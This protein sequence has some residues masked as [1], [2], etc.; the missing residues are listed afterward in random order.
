MK[1]F[2][3]FSMAL[4][5]LNVD[6][7]PDTKVY[8]LRVYHCH[9][10]KRDDLIARFQNHTTRIFEKHG[11]TNVAYWLPTS[12]D[13]KNDLIYM[14]SYPSMEA[15]QAAWKAFSADPEWQKVAADSQKDGKIVAA[16]DS[17]FL[18]MEPELTKKLKLKA[19]SPERTFELRSYY[20]LPGRY[21]NIV[22]RFRDHT[23]DIFETHGIENIAYWGTIEKENTQPHLVYI[24]A[25]ESEAAAKTSWDAFRADPVW[26]K[27][28]KAS[29]ED[30]KIVEKV[31]SIMMEPLPFSKLK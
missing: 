23:R 11:M 17:K 24:I 6:A 18:K 1:L 25:H 13:M 5:A 30:G 12:P 21:P 29:E 10:G 27:A 3:L 15:R 28:Q 9:E 14:L 7:K 31:V 8:E 26:K 22:A 16:V 2:L 20:C 4:L 19:K